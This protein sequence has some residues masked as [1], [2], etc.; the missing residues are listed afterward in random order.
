MNPTRLT[1]LLFAGAALASASALCS[2]ADVKENYTRMCARCHAADGSGNTK[3]GQKLNV[4]DYTS[5]EVQAKMTDE[6]I[7]KV[8]LEGAKDKDTGKEKMQAYKAKLSEQEAKD[9]V[10][11]VRSFKK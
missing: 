1:R 9:L 11:L 4:K 7:L 6:E 5:A 8:I 10:T 3:A 2:A